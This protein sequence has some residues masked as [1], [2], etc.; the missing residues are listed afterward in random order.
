MPISSED[1]ILKQAAS[2]SS[3]ALHI[4]SA[5]LALVGGAVLIAFGLIAIFPSRLLDYFTFTVPVLATQ[6][7]F[8]GGVLT[9]LLGAISVAAATCTSKW[10]CS[11]ALFAVSV[12]VGGVGGSLVLLSAFFGLISRSYV[13]KRK[14]T[15]S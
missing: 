12:A 7:L 5:V 1:G 2:R 14:E 3:H 13:Q 4:S 6:S 9:V 15:A 8:T 10:A 11:A